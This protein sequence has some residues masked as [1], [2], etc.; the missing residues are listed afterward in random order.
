MSAKDFLLST[1]EQIASRAITLGLVLL[2][3]FLFNCLQK[4]LGVLVARQ[5]G[6]I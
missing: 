4:R 1:T 3:K 5:V 6:A 2:C